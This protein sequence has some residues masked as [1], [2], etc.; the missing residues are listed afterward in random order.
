MPQ[1]EEVKPFHRLIACCAVLNFDP[2]Y[3]SARAAVQAGP[4]GRWIETG[5]GD[6]RFAVEARVAQALANI[7]EL[8]GDMALIKESGHG[9]LREFNRLPQSE[10]CWT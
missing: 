4:S 3:E 9:E 8:G 10:L 1:N 5:E 7:Q 2:R 6:E